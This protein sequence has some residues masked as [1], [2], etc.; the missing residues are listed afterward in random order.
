MYWQ[1]IIVN[2]NVKVARCTHEKGT[3]ICDKYTCPI[4]EYA[5]IKLEGEKHETT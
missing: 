5:G 3:G 4:G 1:W 2:G